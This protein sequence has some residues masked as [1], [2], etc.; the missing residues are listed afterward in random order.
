MPAQTRLAEAG[1]GALPFHA[2]AGCHAG[3]AQQ[4]SRAPSA[5]LAPAERFAVLE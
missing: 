5:A 2:A 4:L 1:A 3:L